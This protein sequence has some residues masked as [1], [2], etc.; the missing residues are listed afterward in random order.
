MVTY[1]KSACPQVTQLA[2]TK[3]KDLSLKSFHVQGKTK[4]RFKD[5]FNEHRRQVDK[6][7][8][9][10]EH[11]LSHTSHSNTDMQ[12]IPPEIIHSS[13]DSIRKAMHGVTF[14]REG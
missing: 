8:T 6:P 11:F 12:L 5:R 13:G 1:D 3:R 10:S 4:R 2:I 14:D 9:V 7:T